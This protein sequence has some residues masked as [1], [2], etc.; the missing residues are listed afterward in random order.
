[1]VMVTGE[2]GG[3]ENAT[4]TVPLEARIPRGTTTIGGG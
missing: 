1:M 3:A 2:L 4:A